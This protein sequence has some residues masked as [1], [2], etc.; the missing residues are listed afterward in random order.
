MV[1]VGCKQ[2]PAV[3]PANLQNAALLGK[4][5]LKQ[6]VIT[7]DD[8]N[9]TTATLSDFT[10][11]D[12]FEF[13]TGNEA[14]FSSP[15]LYNNLYIGYYSANSGTTPNTL[16]FKSGKFAL[17][18]FID[19]VDETELKVYEIITNTDNGTTSTNQYEYTY[20]RIP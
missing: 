2:D 14:T 17:K 7:P 16:S 19:N 8:P 12:F 20:N 5:Y 13:R 4:W 18:Y 6:L 11:S 15:T 9:A 3:V 10:T 1:A